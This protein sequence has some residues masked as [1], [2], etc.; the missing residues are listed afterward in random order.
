MIFRCLEIGI[1]KQISCIFYFLT[2]EIYRNRHVG[3]SYSAVLDNEVLVP[4]WKQEKPTSEM[5][6]VQS[7]KQEES[8]DMRKPKWKKGSIATFEDKDN[9]QPWK[10]TVHLIETCINR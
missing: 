3:R 4:V 2:L 5:K 9:W 1:L 8:S 10:G 6:F 7:S